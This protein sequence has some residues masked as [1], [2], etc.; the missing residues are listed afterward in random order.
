MVIVAGHVSVE[1]QPREAYLAGCVSVVEQ[2][3]G[4]LAASIAPSPPI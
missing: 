1:P 3:R 4:R 2:A